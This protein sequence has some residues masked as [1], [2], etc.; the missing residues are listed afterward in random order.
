[1]KFFSKILLVSA[2]AGA[3]LLAPMVVSAQAVDLD[4]LLQQVR[5]GRA[6]DNATNRQRI[7]EFQA[8]R[9]RQAELLAEAKR[10]RAQG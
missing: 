10:L 4:Q 2:I 3:T 7:A 1:M 8:N 9:A 5:S 6:A